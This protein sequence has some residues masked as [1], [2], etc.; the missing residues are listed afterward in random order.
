MYSY[1][2]I[3]SSL[4]EKFILSNMALHM[5]NSVFYRRGSKNTLF[6]RYCINDGLFCVRMFTIIHFW[7]Y[8]NSPNTA[9]SS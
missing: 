3:Y 9:F 1:F 8:S 6:I 4:L 7:T 2:K 5:F